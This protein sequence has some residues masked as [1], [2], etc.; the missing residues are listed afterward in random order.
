M[1]NLE[2]FSKLKRRNHSLLTEP[3]ERLY[4]NASEIRRISPFSKRVR[5]NQLSN[6]EYSKVLPKNMLYDKE[7]LYL[8]VLALKVE[9]NQIMDENIRLKT[10]IVTLERDL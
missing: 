2:L 1:N 6:A 4:K 5:V 7:S 8:E 10:R 9:L 3:Q